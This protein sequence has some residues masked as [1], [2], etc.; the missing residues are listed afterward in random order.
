MR[1]VTGAMKFTCTF[2]IKK[3]QPL[4]EW[5]VRKN[6]NQVEKLRRAN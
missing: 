2:T 4:D 5:Q 6:L 3:P 1:I